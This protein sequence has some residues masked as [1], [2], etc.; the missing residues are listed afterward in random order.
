MSL[1]PVR[2]IC[3]Y[4]KLPQEHVGISIDETK[5]FWSFPYEMTRLL[6]WNTLDLKLLFKRK[7]S[8]EQRIWVFLPPLSNTTCKTFAETLT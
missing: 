5:S 8:T 1:V 4:V 3:N 2:P 6:A 7:T